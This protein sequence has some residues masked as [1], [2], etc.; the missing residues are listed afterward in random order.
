MKHSASISLVELRGIM[1]S[2]IRVPEPQTAGRELETS[3]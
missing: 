3:Q 1:D 2:I